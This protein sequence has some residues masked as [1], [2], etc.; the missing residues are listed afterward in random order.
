M[1]ADIKIINFKLQ[2]DLEEKIKNYIN[3]DELK[4]YEIV[5]SFSPA[6]TDGNIYV[7]LILQREIEHN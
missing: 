5:S 2:A 6:V 1:A 7:Y 3:S 4:G